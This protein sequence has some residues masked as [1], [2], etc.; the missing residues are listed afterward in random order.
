MAVLSGMMSPSVRDYVADAKMVK[1]SS[2][3]RVIATTLGLFADDLGAESRRPGGWRTYTLLV[4]A[5]AT[6]G[7][8]PTGDARWA[9]PAG[10]AGAGSLDGHLV[11]NAAGYT[12]Y[13]ES[14]GF[15]WRGAYISDHVGSDP[16]GYRYA[17]NVGGGAAGNIDM[18]VLSGG[19][20]GVIE[21]PFERD[22]ITAGGD[23]VLAL[24]SAGEM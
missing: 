1:A 2:D 16:W 20:N 3:V 4:S 6:P 9:M 7:I 12:P 15:G 14:T 24:V 11:T 17:I 22:G 8:A 19:P 13:S 23:D 5:G 10:G 18:I 21:T